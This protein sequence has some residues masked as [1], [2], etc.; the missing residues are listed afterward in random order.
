M[1]TIQQASIRV[2]APAEPAHRETTDRPR[3]PRAWALATGFVML[4]VPLTALAVAFEWRTTWGTPDET[5]PIVSDFLKYGSA[6]SGPLAP[7]LALLVLAALAYQ[8]RRRLSA[9]ASV[10][11][12]LVGL[13]VAFNGAMELVSDPT[14]TPRPVLVASGLLFISLGSLL[15][16]AAA[17]DVLE[18]R[19]TTK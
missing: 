3:L 7:Q 19:A 6:V 4:Q 1:S 16:T 17:R 5:G 11:I 10:G 13:L 14:W 15:A 2:E 12:G 9:S 8:R 18:Q